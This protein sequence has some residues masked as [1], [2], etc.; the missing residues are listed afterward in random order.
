LYQAEGTH[1]PKIP[2]AKPIP[3]TICSL[4]KFLIIAQ[5]LVAEV[6]NLVH[7]EAVLVD[8]LLGSGQEATIGYREGDIPDKTSLLLVFRWIA[9]YA[10]SY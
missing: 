2:P 7:I 1:P 8:R 9:R 3:D 4:L 6:S 5:M 10:A